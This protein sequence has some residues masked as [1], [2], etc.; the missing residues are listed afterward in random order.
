MKLHVI[1]CIEKSPKLVS[2]LIFLTLPSGNPLFWDGLPQKTLVVSATLRDIQ[3]S[4]TWKMG[5]GPRLKLLFGGWT[6]F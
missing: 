2:F 5:A 3:I 4:K 1:D 6:K